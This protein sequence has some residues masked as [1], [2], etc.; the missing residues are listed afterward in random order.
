MNEA[1]LPSPYELGDAEMLQMIREISHL[2]LVK[3]TIHTVQPGLSKARVT[4][5]QLELLS[6]TESH[7]VEIYEI[8]FAVIGT[9]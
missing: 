2:C 4:P 9:S 3:L 1:G 7:L 8:P 6:E 5:D